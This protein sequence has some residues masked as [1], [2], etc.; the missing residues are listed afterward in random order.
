MSY[1]YTRYLVTQIMM[2]LWHRRYMVPERQNLYVEIYGQ[3]NTS[4]IMQWV[5]VLTKIH[6]L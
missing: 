4:L 6:S 2:L 1:Q 3:A 5:M